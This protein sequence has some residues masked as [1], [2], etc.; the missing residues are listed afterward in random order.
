M[1][2]F[3]WAVCISSECCGGPSTYATLR[4]TDCCVQWTG[5]PHVFT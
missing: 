4:K 1:D 2:L 5:K 3:I